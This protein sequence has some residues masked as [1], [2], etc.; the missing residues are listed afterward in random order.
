MFP[1]LHADDDAL[2]FSM[3]GDVPGMQLLWTNDTIT[4]GKWTRE[5]ERIDVERGEMVVTKHTLCWTNIHICRHRSTNASIHAKK[6]A[7]RKQFS[8]SCKACHACQFRLQSIKEAGYWAHRFLGF[9]DMG[10]CSPVL[11]SRPCPRPTQMHSKFPIQPTCINFR[12]PFV[13][14]PFSLSLRRPVGPWNLSGFIL[15]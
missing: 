15:A 6:K 4:T 1:F 14:C 2:F 7:N 9:G 10:F 5:K 11:F 13:S 12:G 3:A 8:F